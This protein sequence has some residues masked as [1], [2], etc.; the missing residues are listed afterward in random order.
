MLNVIPYGEGAYICWPQIEQLFELE[1]LLD[2][3]HGR[4]S[5]IDRLNAEA[6]A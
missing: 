3:V 6:V 1:A 5:Q 2:G 4:E